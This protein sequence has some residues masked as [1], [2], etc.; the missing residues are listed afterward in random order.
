MTDQARARLVA[1]TPQAAQA[2]ASP[3][4]AHSA[5]PAKSLHDCEAHLRALVNAAADAIVSVDLH[6]TI[7]GWNPAAQGL[8]GYTQDE[9]LGQSLALLMQERHWETHRQALE[10]MGASGQSRL[11]GKPPE[12]TG[13]HKDGH[14]FPLELAAAPWTCPCH[15]QTYVTVIARDL[16]ERKQIEARA[17]R[18][19]RLESLSTL[20]GGMAHDLNN[21]LTPILMGAQLLW[22]KA[23]DEQDRQLLETILASTQRAAGVVRQVLTFARGTYGQRVTL[24]PRQLLQQVA[25]AARAAFPH[26]IRIQTVIAPDLWPLTGDPAQLRELFL[27]LCANARDAMPAGGCLTLTA[28]NLLLSEPL[29]LPEAEL[30]PGRHVLCQVSDEGRGIPPE[31]LGRIFEPFFT[32]KGVGQGSGL[33]LSA[34][35]GILRSHGGAIRVQSKVNCGATFQVYLPAATSPQTVSPPIPAPAP[36]AGQG[37][38]ILVVEDEA[39]LRESAKLA[40]ET[41]GYRVITADNG[42]SGLAHYFKH[43]DAIK[44]VLTDTM[45]PGMDGVALVRALRHLDHRLPIVSASGHAD[46]EKLAELRAL[47]VNQVLAKPYSV[48]SLLAA[49]DAALR[50]V[51]TPAA[52]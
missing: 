50:S 19:H 26:N 4:A 43:R 5:P 42:A 48:Q 34:V 38:L 21:I 1:E 40:L 29:S 3:P 25:S 28:A 24:A 27:N 6:G 44:A 10:Q 22:A 31:I 49:L 7:V 11:A 47:R 45:M 33:G 16:T 12:T 37:H 32:T 52:A 35:L 9:A 36:A 20:A 41:R 8:F 51:A 30:Q 17:L 13:R 46:T 39:D 15:G 14:E 23:E 18:A 2:A